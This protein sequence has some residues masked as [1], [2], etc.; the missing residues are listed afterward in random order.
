MSQANGG[1]SRK[2]VER[3][4]YVRQKADGSRYFEIGYR[5]S[6]GRQRWQRVDGGIMAARAARDDVLG[7]KGRGERVQPN[8]KLRFNDAADAWL[9]GQ[10][11]SLRPRTREAYAYA[12]QHIRDRFG[13]RRL[14]RIST[15]DA[16]R[17]VRE[18]RAEGKSEATNDAARK[19]GSRVYRFA[20]RRLG[21]HGPNP[22]DALERG[23]RPKAGS[24]A[25]R[26]MFEGDELAQTLEAATHPW[27]ALFAV[28]AVTGARLSEVLGL[29]WSD[30][31]LRDINEA[32]IG[33]THQVDRAGM[34]APL[35]TDT[36]RRTIEIPRD[37]AVMLVE[38]KLASAFADE[39][40][41]VFVSRSGR[42]LGQRN[43]AR[44]LREAQKRATRDD[45]RPAFPRLHETTNTGEARP[46]ARGEIP[47][48]HAFRH[49]FASLAIAHGDSA[50][51]VSW[52][53]GHK[54]SAVTRAVY[55]HEIKNGERSAERRERIAR[56]FRSVLRGESADSSSG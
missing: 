55:I 18:L 48:F 53:L 27:K 30:I 38:H 51:E 17:L 37:L 52:Q 28:A 15:D 54:S 32:S 36:S 25:S 12:L 20:T 34:K 45:G 8:P 39:A 3:N 4:I 22:F 13:H 44:A 41:F 47:S 9:E 6:T 10:V 29:Q 31:D 14:D 42:A 19:A 1:T 50:E 33:F 43:V 35:K 24:A 26:R 5:D 49:T 46:L 2:N 56:R 23:E 40:C 21:W 11:A 16:A 7:R